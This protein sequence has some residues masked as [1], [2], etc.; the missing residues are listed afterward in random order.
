M[1]FCPEAEICQL[2]VGDFVL[3]QYG[4]EHKSEPD[5]FSSLYS[6]HLDEQIANMKQ[7][8]LQSAIVVSAPSSRIL[9][10]NASIGYCAS[11]S[12]R[13]VPVIIADNLITA[14]NLIHRML[15]KWNDGKDRSYDAINRR[16]TRDPVINTLTGIPFVSHDMADR[17]LAK[18]PTVADLCLASID[19][20]Q[21]VKGIGPKIS[22]EIYITLH[23]PKW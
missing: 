14:M 23:T 18:F 12:A 15:T 22:K 13:G 21:T 3:G 10:S 7:T 19:D 8:F 17:L 9:T 16:V 11:C 1:R 20:L 2:E 5:F 4:I 6:G